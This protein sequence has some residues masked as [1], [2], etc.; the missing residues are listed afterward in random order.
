[1]LKYLKKS[2]IQDF[3]AFSIDPFPP[4]IKRDIFKLFPLPPLIKKGTFP[5]KKIFP[6]T[7]IV[8]LKGTKIGVKLFSTL[9]TLTWMLGLVMSKWRL[10]LQCFAGFWRDPLNCKWIYFIC[11]A[12]VNLQWFRHIWT[13]LQGAEPARCRFAISFEL[14]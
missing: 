5:K 4:T 10:T 8:N 14:R 6:I 11:K 12:I 9:L 7:F 2:K 13:N 1:M 3:V